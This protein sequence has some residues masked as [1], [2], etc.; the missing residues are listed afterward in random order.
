LLLSA[1]NQSLKQVKKDGL[2]ATLGLC[3]GEDRAEAFAALS[4]A[5]KLQ[6][7]GRDL[8]KLDKVKAQ[9]PSPL[10]FIYL[11]SFSR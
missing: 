11:F 6:P 9:R 3:F 2:W 1:H 4:L 10:V 5:R 8:Q 7:A